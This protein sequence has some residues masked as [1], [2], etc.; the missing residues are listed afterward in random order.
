MPNDGEELNLFIDV[1]TN[2]E[3]VLG[4]NEWLVTCS[5]SAGPAFEG[6]GISCGMRAMEGAIDRV[7]IERESLKASYSVIDNVKPAGICGSGLI[8]ALS[9]MRDAGIIDRAGNMKSDYL[10]A[11]KEESAGGRDIVITES[12][13]KN[14]LRAKAAI[15]AGIR[16]MLA[17]V[18]MDVTDISKIYIAGGFGNCIN[19]TDAV[20]IGMLPDLPQDRYE[21]V[22][23]SCI[24]G[25]VMGLLS[26][27]ALSDM[28]ELAGKMTYIELSIGN[29]FMD[30][31]MSALFIPHTDF[32]LFPSL[33]Q[34]DGQPG[35]G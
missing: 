12:D 32:S 19:I 20:Q 27:D 34:D 8:C 29:Q 2:G 13:V 7:E 24:K 3:M 5:C 14:L 31:F 6:S 35:K 17:Q 21:Y 23:N 26:K 22:G 28:H 1:G 30:E 33:A 11:P 25:A 9:E 4:N 16:T 18:Q 10:I 15:F